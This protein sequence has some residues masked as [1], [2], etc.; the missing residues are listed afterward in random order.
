MNRA[1]SWL[2]ITFGIALF[3]VTAYLDDRDVKQFTD[4][5]SW[6]TAEAKRLLWIRIITRQAAAFV[7]V[8]MLDAL[9]TTVSYSAPFWQQQ[10]SRFFLSMA[11]AANLW[12]IPRYYRLIKQAAARARALL[13]LRG[14]QL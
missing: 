13:A 11:E 6:Q 8:L 14:D 7:L 5:A 3:V 2:V 1:W 10:A 9:S 4:P 12:Q